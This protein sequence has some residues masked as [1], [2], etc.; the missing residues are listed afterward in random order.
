MSAARGS[1]LLRHQAQE[2]DALGLRPGEIEEL[3]AEHA[4]LA[5]RGACSR[6]C[7]ARS[8]PVR[9]RRSPTAQALLAKSITA[10]RARQPPWMRNSRC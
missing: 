1:N 8:R 6:P 9:V 3:H 2:I 5:N 4:R 10:L 7:A